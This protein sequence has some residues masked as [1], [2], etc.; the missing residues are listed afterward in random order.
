MPGRVTV[1]VS[2]WLAG[3][4]AWAGAAVP[5]DQEPLAAGQMLVKFATGGPAD[6]E[7][8]RLMRSGEPGSAE[9]DEYVQALV[10]I[11]DVP[12]FVRQITSGRELVLEIERSA[13]LDRAAAKLREAAGVQQVSIDRASGSQQYWDDRLVVVPAPDSD[14][15]RAALRAKDAG[16]AEAMYEL[17]ARQF[18]H[19]HYA[20]Q[21]QAIEAPQIELRI[22][23]QK[24]TLSVIRSLQA[25]ADVEYAQPN[26]VATIN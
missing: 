3:V 15:A 6:T 17:L 2:A 1:L 18:A 8:A 19:P 11:L 20:L 14:L 25:R 24:T 4:C 12:L 5:A 22:D 10:A 26:F 21:A 9:L 16:K 7:I 13:V 23:L